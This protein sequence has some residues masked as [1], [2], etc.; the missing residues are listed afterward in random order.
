M[1]ARPQ[2]GASL[3]RIA[4][5]QWPSEFPLVQFPNAPLIVALAASVAGGLTHGQAHRACRSVFYI[6]L[7]IWAYEEARNGDNWFRRLLGAGALLY[8][9]S[10]IAGELPS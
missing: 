1:S 9:A 10:S 8:I 3:E 7:A 6:A 4:R 5:W 2:I